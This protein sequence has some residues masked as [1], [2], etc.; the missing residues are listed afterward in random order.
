MIDS[1]LNHGNPLIM[2]IMVRTVAQTKIKPKTV[3][4]KSGWETIQNIGNVIQ[5]AIIKG[6]D[7]SIITLKPCQVCGYPVLY[8]ENAL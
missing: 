6:I 4:L 5:T 3:F 7:L 1:R 8:R 2:Q